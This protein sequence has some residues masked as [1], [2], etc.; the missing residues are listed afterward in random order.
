MKIFRSLFVVISL[1][2]FSKGYCVEESVVPS[3]LCGGNSGPSKLV[4]GVDFA[5]SA[6]RSMTFLVP[7]IGPQLGYSYNAKT[8]SSITLNGLKLGC[9]NPFFTKDESRVYMRCI[10]DWKKV[11]SGYLFSKRVELYP[12]PFKEKLVYY[13]YA[14]DD[15]FLNKSIT[16]FNGLGSSHSRDLIAV[17]KM[18]VDHG[19]SSIKFEVYKFDSEYGLQLVGTRDYSG[20]FVEN[21]K[22]NSTDSG[23]SFD[24]FDGYNTD[25]L[26]YSGASPSGDLGSAYQPGRKHL[27]Y[28]VSGDSLI[29]PQFFEFTN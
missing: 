9:K 23:V 27:F 5:C 1:L 29:G 7:G 22:F 20:R 13:E 24:L 6:D 25:Q 2:I 4:E 3:D 21:I 16:D 26:V 19:R 28:R 17:S 11:Y 12:I 15:F 8:K 14:E 18:V 10:V